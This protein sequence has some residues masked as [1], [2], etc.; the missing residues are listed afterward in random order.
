MVSLDWSQDVSKA[1]GVSK[2][3]FLEACGESMFLLFQMLGD[4]IPYSC[5]TEVS[6]YL[7]AVSWDHTHK[8]LFVVHNEG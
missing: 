2:D 6:V 4:L 8:S 5:R 3:P 7:M 1:P